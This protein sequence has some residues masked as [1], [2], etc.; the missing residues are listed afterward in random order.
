MRIYDAKISF[1][2]VQEGPAEPV[3]NAAKVVEYMRGAFDELP[4]NECFY[5]IVLNRKNRPMGRHKVT[6]GTQTAALAHPRE[7][8]RVAVMASAAAIICVHNHPSGDPAP[9]AADLQITNLLRDGAKT[10]EISLIDHVI[11]GNLMDD[12]RGV[13]YYS[14]REAGIL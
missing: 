7:V 13:G 8:F 14:F 2:L 3:G 6:V 4:L 1:H 12:P 10:L 9:S 11:I 5:V